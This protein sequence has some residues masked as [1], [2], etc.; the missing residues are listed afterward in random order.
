MKAKNGIKAGDSQINTEVTMKYDSGASFL[1][2]TDWEL[3][4]KPIDDFDGIFISIAKELGFKCCIGQ[5]WPALLIFREGMLWREEFSLTL[6]RD[7]LD[8]NVVS[9]EL[10]HNTYVGLKLFNRK[11]EKSE[12]LIVFSA[13]E[14]TNNNA[15][16]NEIY[17]RIGNNLK[18]NP[19]QR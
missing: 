7:Y 6:K 18:G 14:L 17:V 12:V 2:K 10:I 13:E 16:S 19:K 9:F 5:R 3:A 15:A 1:S 8:D 4:T 11:V